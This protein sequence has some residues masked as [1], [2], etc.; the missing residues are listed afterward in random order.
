MCIFTLV[1][2]PSL[3]SLYAKNSFDN[4]LRNLWSPLDALF[5]SFYKETEIADFLQLAI[6]RTGLPSSFYS[7]FGDNYDRILH[8]EILVYSRSLW[9]SDY[10]IM[11][12]QNYEI[13]N[14]QIAH[15]IAAHFV[16]FYQDHIA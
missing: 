13:M 9:Q 14:M 1:G 11:Y 3:D 12:F 6:C 5:L 10:E 16:R 7:V 15:C 8:G 2:K 4:K